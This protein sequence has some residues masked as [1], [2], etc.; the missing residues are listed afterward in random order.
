M[1][2]AGLHKTGI[3]GIQDTRQFAL[4][5]TDEAGPVVQRLDRTQSNVYLLQ[6]TRQSL[7][8]ATA[9]RHYYLGFNCLNDNKCL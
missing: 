1:F 5:Y 9:T 8:E 6:T 2:W 3:R 7:T 4:S